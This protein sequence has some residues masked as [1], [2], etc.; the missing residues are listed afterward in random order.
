MASQKPNDPHAAHQQDQIAQQGRHQQLLAGAR[1]LQQ[2]GVLLLQQVEV[3]LL[4]LPQ[5]LMQLLSPKQRK[6]GKTLRSALA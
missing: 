5:Q 6:H 3:L 2:A 4:L 1:L